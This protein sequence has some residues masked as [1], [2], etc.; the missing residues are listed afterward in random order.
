MKFETLVTRYKNLGY[1]PKNVDNEIELEC[2]INWI[3]KT[4]NVFIYLMYNDLITQKCFKKHEP[5]IN[6]F[7]A[8]KIQQCNT[9]HS[10]IIYSDKYF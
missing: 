3:Y 6:F 4:Y 7:S 8:H 1:Q 10:N 2:L 9:E 5:N